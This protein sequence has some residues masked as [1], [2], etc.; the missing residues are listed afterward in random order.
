MEQHDRHG[1]SADAD[2]GNRKVQELLRSRT[3]WGG[4]ERAAAA[5]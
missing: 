2:K 1:A 3:G 4:H 5:A